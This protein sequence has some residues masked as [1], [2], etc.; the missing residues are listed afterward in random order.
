M[1]RY[2]MLLGTDMPYMDILRQVVSRTTQPVHQA[3]S[4]TAAMYTI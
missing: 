4:V 2:L 1:F 3:E